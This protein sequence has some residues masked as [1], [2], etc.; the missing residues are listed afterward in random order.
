[1]PLQKT[2]VFRP[3]TLGGR[4]HQFS[5]VVWWHDEDCALL[6]RTEKEARTADANFPV[7]RVNLSLSVVLASRCKDG[8]VEHDAY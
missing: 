2:H 4:K 7:K 3:P 8:E 5:L 1:M 6:V